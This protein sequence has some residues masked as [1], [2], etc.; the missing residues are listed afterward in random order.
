M[1]YNKVFY[2]KEFNT[3]TEA[4][5]YLAGLNDMVKRGFCEVEIR[6]QLVSMPGAIKLIIKLETSN[7]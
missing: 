4:M 6:S 7:V 1:I 2:E 3:T 5:A